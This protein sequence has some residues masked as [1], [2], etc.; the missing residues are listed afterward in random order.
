[1][2]ELA[3]GET[4]HAQETLYECVKCAEGSSCAT[5]APE[6]CLAGYHCLDYTKDPKAFATPPGTYSPD[7]ASTSIDSAQQCTGGYCPPAS[8]EVT[9]CP[10][11]YTASL[12]DLV[13][14]AGCRPDEARSHGGTPCPLGSFCPEATVA[15]AQIPCSPGL[16]GLSSDAAQKD[17]CQPCSP[18][19]F[20]PAGTADS[21]EA[22]PEG[23]VCPSSTLSSS[24][25]ADNVLTFFSQEHACQAGTHSPSANDGQKQSDCE[26]CSEGKYCRE[27]TGATQEAT[28]PAHSFCEAGQEFKR[29]CPIGYYTNG[30]GK[31][32]E[33]DC[34][35]CPEGEYCP[36]GA[37]NAQCPGGTYQDE[38]GQ[39]ACKTTP[40][41][42]ATSEGAD[43]I[44]SSDNCAAGTHAREGA[45]TCYSCAPGEECPGTAESNICS[46]GTF[47][48]GGLG[49]C[50]QCESGTFCDEQGLVA[51]KPCPSGHHCDGVTNAPEAA[52]AL[53][54]SKGSLGAVSDWSLYLCDS[55]YYCPEEGAIGPYDT[56]CE[57]GTYSGEGE[58]SCQDVQDG[59]FTLRGASSEEECPQ[60]YYCNHAEF[61]Y[62]IPCPKGT[63]GAAP[64]LTKSQ[65][66]GGCTLC[67]GGRTCDLPGLQEE[68]GE[69]DA[70]F[71][72]SQGAWT[73]R[74][75]EDSGTGGLCTAGHYCP[76]GVS[77]PRPC[78]DGTYLASPG[79]KEASDCLAC[80]AGSYCAGE[81][82]ETPTDRCE[83]GYFCAGGAS[84]ATEE[85][86]PAGSYTPE[87][88]AS[89]IACPPGTFSSEPAQAECQQCEAGTYCSTTGLTEGQPCDAGAY[90]PAGAVHPIICP[91]G[92][93]Q[94]EA[95]ADASG[96]CLE[97]PEG[98]YCPDEGL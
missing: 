97:C 47:S 71:Y 94:P 3:E 87:G 31:T 91:A 23:F 70:G 1:M 69:C 29:K 59:Y 58:T 72:C 40:E 93:Y 62:P 15:D 41:G 39:S 17:G 56:P 19:A 75:D 98:Q 7:P 42:Q 20:C 77:A 79:M 18:G 85:E 25:A 22:C 84:E 74:P 67:S 6:E 50:S 38:S 12:T 48:P 10:D 68:Y 61:T 34:E 51:A 9:A 14:A 88:S 66:T 53:S 2:V 90:C 4:E 27:G 33:D 35:Q 95:S 44:S 60:G 63:F 37:G 8:T 82:L 16:R 65:G 76:A 21:M 55:G 46:E 80:P 11:G 57:A 89:P 32:T 54:Y 78:D 5:S 73:P 81:G 86:T 49:T 43:S 52:P 28:C 36:E 96:A 26:T 83:A 30:E 64:G 92:S 45:S 13:D 24:T